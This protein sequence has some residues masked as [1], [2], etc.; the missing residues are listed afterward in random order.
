V[1]SIVNYPIRPILSK[2]LPLLE[3]FLYEAI[4][5]PAG[6]DPLP[7]EVIRRPE[8]ALYIEDFGRPGD[9]CLVA[10]VDGRLAGAVWV[11]LFPDDRK[12][13]GTLDSDTPE[14]SISL[15]PQFRNR[16]IGRALLTAM[17]DELKT[18]GFRRV[19][20]SVQKENAAAG[21]YRSLGFDVVEEVG[22]EYIMACMLISIEL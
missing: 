4:Y 7:R 18:A 3:D 20:L 1:P 21:L 22:D 8:I 6:S 17:L 12:G 11:R 16:G 5:Q 2:E 15:Y 13:Y 9:C 14:L 10:E 19:S